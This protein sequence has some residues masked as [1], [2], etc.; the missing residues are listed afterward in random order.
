MVNKKW[1]MSS[2]NIGYEYKDGLALFNTKSQALLMLNSEYK[3]KYIQICNDERPYPED[4][5]KELISGG[6]LVDAELNEYESLQVN[7]RIARYSNRSLQLTIAPT[8]A[9]NFACPYCFE[10]NKGTQV[11]SNQTIRELISFVENRSQG[12]RRLDVAWYGGE[13]LLQI[14][15]IETV[16]SKLQE[17]IPPDCVYASSIITNGYFLTKQVVEILQKSKVSMAQVTLDGSRKNHDSRRTLIDGSPTYDY[18]LD[19]IANAADLI[20]IVIRANIDQDNVSEMKELLFN[21]KNRG[22]N[23]KVGIYL[24]LTDDIDGDTCIDSCHCIS[25]R[26]FSD[27]EISF[28]E[29]AI[30]MGFAVNMFSGTAR[31]ICSAVSVNSFLIGPNGDIC[32]C[33]DDI[34][35]KDS[36]SGHV[37]KGFELTSNAVKWLGYLPDNEKCK[38]CNVFPLC[39]GGCPRVSLLNGELDCDTARYNIQQ[40]IRLMLLAHEIE[41]GDV[42]V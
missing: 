17:I 25:A 10:K 15:V 9:C 20:D 8:L 23:K 36:V 38:T 30:R 18:I 34:G 28:Y 35:V 24:A 5:A 37:S 13:P 31:S 33:W 27:S 42:D 39:M 2:Y 16:S 19:N 14:D 3:N 12:V 29:E 22:L 41:L 32:N 7:S 40:K 1:K 4:L 6:M 11:M 21:L 26:D